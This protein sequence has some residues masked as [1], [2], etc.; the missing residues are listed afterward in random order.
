MSEE[1]TPAPQGKPYATLIAAVIFLLASLLV[2]AMLLSGAL[3]PL[4]IL[5]P[6]SPP[7]PQPTLTASPT[8]TA[9]PQ[10]NQ[11]VIPSPSAT[12]TPASS[13]SPTP[14]QATWAIGVAALQ[15][16]S[17]PAITARLGEALQAADPAPALSSP[18]EVREVRLL[19]AEGGIA[20]INPAQ[21]APGCALLLIWEPVGSS[22]MRVY[23]LASPSPPLLAQIEA[24]AEAWQLLTPATFPLIVRAQGDEAFVAGVALGLLELLQGAIEPALTRVQALVALSPDLPRQ[25]A[26]YNEAVLD[27]L[28]ALAADR[29]GD[30]IA[31][32]EAYSQAIRLRSDFVA[33]LVNR[34]NIYLQAGD[35]AAALE[36]YNRALAIE[37]EQVAALYNRALAYRAQ[38]DQVAALEDAERLALLYAEAWS[39]NLRGLIAYELGDSEAALADFRQAALLAPQDPTPLFNE[40]L[41]LARMGEHGQALVVLDALIELQPQNPVFH[42]YLGD[43]FRLVGEYGQAERAYSE[44]IALNPRYLEAYLRRGRL[45]IEGGDPQG[46]LTD[47]AQALELAPQSGEAYWIKGD[48]LLADEDF[49]GAEEAYSA[50]L[51]AGLDDPAIYAA[52]GWA[53]HRLRFRS[54][55]IENYQQALALGHTD[56]LTLNRLGFAL[57]DAGRYEEALDAMLAAVNAGLDTA[58]GYAGLALALDANIRRDEAEQQYAHALEIDNRYGKAAFLAEQPLWSQAAVSRAVTILRR[59]GIDPYAED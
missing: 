56:P 10:P 19:P 13:A 29:Q 55:A 26:A 14:E 49:A 28:R 42:L 24:R 8:P 48:A 44:A 15:T 53:L 43:A 50:A 18:L 6:S 45:R 16:N 12:P 39:I 54:A 27:F 2:A 1:H 23:L 46:A 22:L 11:T 52:R 7:P 25:T 41:T 38:G 58:E 40:A 57:Y 5:Q 35:T 51:G 37:P 36:G 59:M 4:A 20:T 47:A 21:D 34:S 33:A 30:L 32:L 31:A 17:D 9:S 3:N